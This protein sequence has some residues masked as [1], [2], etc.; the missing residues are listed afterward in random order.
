MK[1]WEYGLR[2]G[3]A[4]LRHDH[5]WWTIKHIDAT[6]GCELIGVAETE[7][8]L[9]DRLKAAR[10]ES[11]LTF[12]SLTEMLNNCSLDA[13]VITAP[14]DEHLPMLLECAAKG[15]HCFLQ[16]PFASSAEEA[17]AMAEAVESSR[18]RVMVNYYPMWSPEYQT[19]FAL[20]R[21]G[22][23]GKAERLLV[24]NGHQG[25]EGIGVL[26]DH[27]KDW[28]Y[29]P[30]KHGGG[31]LVDQGTYGIAYAVMTMGIPKRVQA[32]IKT[33]WPTKNRGVDDDSWLML[34]Y[35][36]GVAVIQG[37]WS[38]PYGGAGDF[39]LSGPSGLLRLRSGMVYL[40]ESE[41]TLKPVSPERQTGIAYFVHCLTTGSPFEKPHDVETN[42][43]VHEIVDAAYESAR[44]GKAINI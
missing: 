13:I 30:L 31:A 25:P 24:S 35:E 14:N 16:K 6:D 27:Y 15:V 22:V 42:V 1:K 28:L 4:N 40:S 12:S 9:V 41:V 36:N 26:T 8:D 3:L 39:S 44:V 11:L 21:E 7:L 5:A 17:R 18:I 33:L 34:E 19:L 20:W 32:C 23:V 2:L 10:D 38:L 43:S 37:S 29:N